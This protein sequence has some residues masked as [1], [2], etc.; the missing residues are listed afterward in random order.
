MPFRPGDVDMVRV[1][2]QNSG[3]DSW[4][5]EMVAHT[6]VP[7]TGVTGKWERPR[8]TLSGCA[9]LGEKA[10]FS[11]ATAV[12]RLGVLRPLIVVMRR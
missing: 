10:P 8:A 9:E 3:A 5:I 4:G 1:R 7:C 12:L 2:V 11:R 6:K